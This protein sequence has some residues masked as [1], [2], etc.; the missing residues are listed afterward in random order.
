[1][2]FFISGFRVG[3]GPFSLHSP[4]W[5]SRSANIFWEESG[6]FFSFVGHTALQ[7]SMLPLNCKS[8]HR[9]HMNTRARLHVNHTLLTKAGSG[10]AWTTGH[11][12]SATTVLYTQPLHPPV[13]SKLQF[14]DHR[15]MR[16][17]DVRKWGHRTLRL[18]KEK[19]RNLNDRTEVFGT[20]GREG[21]LILSRWQN[22]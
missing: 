8:S 7:F 20:H 11:S 12:L 2:C 14:C 4:L 5:T 19:S 6:C 22:P 18:T 9:W 21:H 13:F 16:K 15:H 10:Q 17:E 1:M 3:A